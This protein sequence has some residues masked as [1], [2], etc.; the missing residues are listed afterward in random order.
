M[1]QQSVRKPKRRRGWLKGRGDIKL[2][3]FVEQVTSPRVLLDEVDPCAS[4]WGVRFGEIDD[5]PLEDYEHYEVSVC[6]TK[7]LLQNFRY[8]RHQWLNRQSLGGSGLVSE[9]AVEPDEPSAKA[10]FYGSSA[11]FVGELWFWKLSKCMK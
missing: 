1:K 6:Q 11:K 10:Y 3:Q 8:S 2:Q 7:R 5:R 9:P 4:G